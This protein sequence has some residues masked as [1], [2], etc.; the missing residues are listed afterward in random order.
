MFAAG[1]GVVAFGTV[2]VVGLAIL[3]FLKAAGTD[4]SNEPG[5][6]TEGAIVATEF[7]FTPAR[8]ESGT[9]VELVLRNEGAVYHDLVISGVDGVHLKVLPGEE[10]LVEVTLEPGRYTFYC[11][12]PGH[13]DSGMS[14]ELVVG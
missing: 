10:D 3:V 13:R 5:P 7:R 1:T 14:G 6:L 12:I 2:L 11:T 4:G 9:E 8:V